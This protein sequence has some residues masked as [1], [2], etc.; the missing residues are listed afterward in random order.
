MA[1][2][3][4]N[5]KKASSRSIKADKQRSAMKPGKRTSAEGNTYYESRGNRSDKNKKTGL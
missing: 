1:K 4:K 5:A 2:A 3:K